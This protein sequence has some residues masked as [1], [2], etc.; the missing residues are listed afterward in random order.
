M[1]IDAAVKKAWDE[2]GESIKDK[3]LKVRFMGSDYLVEAGKRTVAK[4]GDSAAAKDYYSLLILH[5]ILNQDNAGGPAGDWISFRDLE[6]GD[7]Y[8][9]VFRQRAIDKIVKK[10]SN[11]AEGLFSNIQSLGA[12]KLNMADAAVQVKAFEKVPVAILLWKQDEELPGDANIL[13]K[14]NI[15]NIF[16]TEDVAVLGEI[17]ASKL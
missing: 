8:Y 13:F 3:A 17:I 6:G 4:L 16:C 14:E 15:K 11:N 7:F 10:Y 1:S 9:S 2:L 12:E 5:Y